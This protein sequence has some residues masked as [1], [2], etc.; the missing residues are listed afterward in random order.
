MP[1]RAERSAATTR[2]ASTHVSSI[3]APNAAR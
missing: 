1:T 2:S 3:P